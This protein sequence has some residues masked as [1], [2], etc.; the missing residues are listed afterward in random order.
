MFFSLMI[1]S[2]TSSESPL[3]YIIENQQ[4]LGQ[5]HEHGGILNTPTY[6]RLYHHDYLFSY[7]SILGLLSFQEEEEAVVGIAFRGLIYNRVYKL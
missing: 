3:L 1:S 5:Q 6:I 2:L 4:F 7:S